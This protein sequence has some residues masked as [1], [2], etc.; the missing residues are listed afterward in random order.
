[1]QIWI[2]WSPSSMQQWLKQLV[3]SSANIIRRKKTWVTAEILDHC[4]KRRT[5]KEK[6]LTWRIWEIK[7][8]EQQPKEAQKKAK[9]NWVGE[10]RSEIEENLR[11]NNSK[12]A[13]QLMKN[14]TTVKPLSTT[15]QDRSGRCLTEEREI[16]NRWT[17]YCSEL[18]NHKANGDLSILNYPHTDPEDNH[19]T[20]TKK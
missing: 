4:D 13:Y 8:S 10:Q 5:E 7:G 18:Y 6:I 19:P 15:I 12:R 20:F 11:K 2:Q 14:L 16:L 1:M 3:R 17:G 9:E